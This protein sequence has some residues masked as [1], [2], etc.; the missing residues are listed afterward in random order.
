S[1]SSLDSEEYNKSKSDKE[2]HAVPPPYT[3]NFIASKPD[4]MFMDEI[5]KSENMDVITVDSPRNVNIFESNHESA[6]VKNNGD[7]VEPKTV[8][9]NS[10]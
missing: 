10:F 3:G 1:S 7:V 9:K 2:Y 6:D 8:R 4:L 5:V